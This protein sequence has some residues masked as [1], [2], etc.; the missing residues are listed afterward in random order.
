MC[1][2]NLNVISKGV[3]GLVRKHTVFSIPSGNCSAGN[4]SVGR[5]NPIHTYTHQSWTPDKPTRDVRTW[6][7]VP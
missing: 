1:I 3:L 7:D 6:Q 4:F 5:S 2:Y